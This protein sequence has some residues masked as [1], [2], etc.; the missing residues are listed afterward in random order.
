MKRPGNAVKATSYTAGIFIIAAATLLAVLLLLSVFGLIHPRKE[1]ITLYT[2]DISKSYDGQPISGTEPVIT[3]GSL[4]TGHQMIVRNIPAFT[5]SG[6]YE[7]KPDVVILD[8]TGADVTDYYDILPAYGTITI[9][10]IPLMLITRGKVKEYDGTPLEPDPLEIFGHNSLLP[11]HTLV[12]DGHNTLTLPGEANIEYVYRILDEDNTDVTAQYDVKEFF[13]TLTVTPLKL[14]ITT[15]SDTALFSGQTM[16]NDDI[17][18]DPSLLL[19]GHSLQVISTTEISQP[20]SVPNE[21]RVRIIDS[22]GVDVTAIYGIEYTFGTLQL[23]PRALRIVTQ[24]AEKIYDGTPLT[25]DQWELDS[26]RLLDGHRIT[27]RQLPRQEQI[28]AMDNAI[29]FVILDESDLDVTNYYSISYD[30]GRLRMQPRPI[31]IRTGSLQKVY[32]GQ[33]L[34]CNSYEIIAGSLAEGDSIELVCITLHSVGTSENF[35]M[36]C[37]IYHISPDGTKQDVTACYRISLDYG[38]LQ[39]I[40]P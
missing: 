37:V 15:G 22:N 2:P 11:G 9:R 35:I 31:T 30:Y 27:I 25:C 4:L 28:G 8:D 21:C 5:L 33:P 40:S 39:I 26:G 10:Q 1:R 17:T 29:E 24:S 19:P 34:N 36:E 23:L 7:N 12:V 3:A 38:Q 32:D 16:R 14:F 13:S 20:Q 18:Y 6:E